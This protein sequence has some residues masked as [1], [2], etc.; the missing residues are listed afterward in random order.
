MKGPTCTICEKPIKG[1]SYVSA[2]GEI[3]CEG[4]RDWHYFACWDCD[5][6]LPLSEV[7]PIG[8]GE[9]RRYVCKRCAEKTDQHTL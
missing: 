6:L 7:V 2:Y 4:C 1:R 3:M 9:K 8:E 5:R